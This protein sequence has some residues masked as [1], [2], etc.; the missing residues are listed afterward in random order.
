MTSSAVTP[1]VNSRVRER[2]RADV[3]LDRD[4]AGRRWTTLAAPLQAPFDLIP[5]CLRNKVTIPKHAPLPRLSA[6][7]IRVR[8]E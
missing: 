5:A 4:D 1:S 6:A 8:F 7:L 3:R 2:D